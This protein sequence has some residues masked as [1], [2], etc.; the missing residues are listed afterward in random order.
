[1]IELKSLP[2]LPVLSP[3][4]CGIPAFYFFI[5]ANKV[6]YLG[7]TK[8]LKRRVR[9]H[10]ASNRKEKLSRVDIFVA[11]LPINSFELLCAS[12]IIEIYFMAR[13]CPLY[14]FDYNT[15]KL[16]PLMERLNGDFCN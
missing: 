9:E 3:K 8:D 12:D 16:C 7:R 1:M 11:W 14:N 6:L 10:L 5:E 4:F 15:Y 13:F 2:K